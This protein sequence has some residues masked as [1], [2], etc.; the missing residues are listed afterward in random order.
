M[1]LFY[2]IQVREVLGDGED[3][4]K[5]GRK[6]LE[7]LPD[8]NHL[9][10]VIWAE[11][12]EQKNKPECFGVSLA[13]RSFVR[14]LYLGIKLTQLGNVENGNNDVKLEDV[15]AFQ[16]KRYR[17]ETTSKY[18]KSED[19]TK[20]KVEIKPPCNSCKIFFGDEIEGN[21]KNFNYFG[22][23]AEYDAIRTANSDGKLGEIKEGYH[24]EKFETACN[25]HLTAFNDLT[26]NLA[27]N[28]AGNLS[29]NHTPVMETYYAKT[30]TAKF[31]KYEWDS[32]KKDYQLKLRKRS[33]GKPN[34]SKMMEDNK[35]TKR[36][37]TTP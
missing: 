10:P 29:P 8:G 25:N 15:N 2:S 17:P 12:A 32:E 3:A 36:M 4:R 35:K 19:E 6:V 5:I 1:S 11:V 24:W 16:M 18:K 26:K 37:K 31:F 14:P 30:R 13:V 21:E 34:N 22:N 9:K 28:D 27:P 20:L 23:C 7:T 33:H